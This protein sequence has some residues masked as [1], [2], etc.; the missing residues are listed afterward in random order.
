MEQSGEKQMADIIAICTH[1]DPSVNHY[2]CCFYIEWKNF[3]MMF[4]S[5]HLKHRKN[6]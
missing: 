5:I 2:L 3:Y 1:I 6:F 4:H